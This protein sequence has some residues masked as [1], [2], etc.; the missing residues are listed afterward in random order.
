M[1]KS[2]GAEQW[3]HNTSHATHNNS[4]TCNSESCQTQTTEAVMKV[5]APPIHC[6][7]MENTKRLI[8]VVLLFSVVSSGF[9]TEDRTIFPLERP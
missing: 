1:S 5:T 2:Q 8:Y 9:D 3:S 7:S 4:R 6:T